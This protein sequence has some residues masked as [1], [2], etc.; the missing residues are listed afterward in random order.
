MRFRESPER[1]VA[2]LHVTGLKLQGFC[3]DDSPAM[4]F[5][6]LSRVRTIGKLAKINLASTSTLS[7]ATGYMICSGAVGSGL[8]TSA[9]GILLVAMGSCALNQFQDRNVDARMQRTR[10][11][12]IPAGQLE[13][14]TALAIAVLL[15][16]AGFLSL[17]M[18]HGLA[19]ALSTM[20]AVLL[21]NGFYAYLKRVW[22]FAA[23]PGAL[24]GSLPPMIGWMAAGGEIS[25]PRII[26]VAFFFFIW[27]VPHFWLLLSIHGRDYEKAGFPSL[28]RIFSSRQRAGLTFVWTVTAAAS[29][30]LL[31]PCGAISS[32]WACLALVA[33][34]LWLTGKSMVILRG[35][36]AP[37]SIRP[38]FR[39]INAY[40]LCI[41]VLLIADSALSR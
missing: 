14:Q 24:I 25:D 1:I 37:Q 22:A 6:L 17:L 5:R 32:P 11:R 13:P 3:G 18:L 12:P 26:A 40:A 9:F 23:V 28:T 38:I 10:S 31:P 2:G 35:N 30:L 41:M 15:I 20:L 8:M 29:A 36:L 34:C 4:Q 21:Y 39:S 19:I 33:C 7:A 16:G 27:Q